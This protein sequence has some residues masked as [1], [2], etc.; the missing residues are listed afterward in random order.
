MHQSNIIFLINDD[1]R[2]VKGKY[3]P[4]SNSTPEMFKT[5]DPTVKVGDLAVV[6]SSTRHGYTVVEITEIDV[7][8]DL[9]SSVPLK[10]IAQRIDLTKFE[11]FVGQECEAIATVQ[12]AERKRKKA[13]LRKTMFGEQEDM[14]NQLKLANHAED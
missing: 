3:D 2:A 4:D 7:E 11:E 9:E 6:Q 13:Q 8:P 1:V 14:V 12:A 5:M 10:W